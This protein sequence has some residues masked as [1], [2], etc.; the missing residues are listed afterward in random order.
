MRKTLFVH[1]YVLLYKLTLLRFVSGISKRNNVVHVVVERESRALLEMP[2][3][4][5]LRQ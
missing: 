1:E 3:S 2:L 4:Y 5:L